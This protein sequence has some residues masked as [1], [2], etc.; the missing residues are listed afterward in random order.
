MFGLLRNCLIISLWLLSAPL[1]AQGEKLYFRPIGEGRGWGQNTIND[2]LQDQQGY[3]WLATWSGLARF[4]GYN[5]QVFNNNQGQSGGLQ[6][7]KITSVFEDSQGR[8]WIGTTYSGFYLYQAETESF[9][10]YL[11]QEDANSLA[12]N[13]IWEIKEDRFGKLWIGT[14][15]GLDEFDPQTETF[16]HYNTG[17]AR[18]N[19][20]H[21]FVYSIHESADGILWVGCETGFNRL[22]RDSAGRPLTFHLYEL[23][24]RGTPI[25]YDDE[26]RH[27]F[28]K[29]IQSSQYF[30]HTLWLG[31]SIGLKKFSYDPADPINFSCHTYYNQP[32]GLNHQFVASLLELPSEEELWIATY[33]GLNILDLKNDKFRYA[34]A[35]KN[36]SGSIPNNTLKSLYLDKF[37]VAW[38]GTDKGLS[39]L[40]LN[41]RPFR[42]LDLDVASYPN[43]NLITT[44][45]ASSDGQG[46]WVGSNGGGL[47]YISPSAEGRDWQFQHFPIQSK[48]VQDLANFV[49]DI[50]ISPEGELWVATQGAGILKMKESVDASGQ[51][52]LNI[53]QQYTKANQL[54]DDYFMSLAP[55]VERGVWFGYWDKGVDWYDPLAERF[56]HFGQLE[57]GPKLTEFPVIELINSQNNG[58]EY[59]WVATRGNGLFQFRFNAERKNLDLLHHFKFEANQSGGLSNDYL[60]C[61]YLQNADTLWIGTENGINVLDIKSGQIQHFS[62]QDGL[63]K[64]WIQSI[65][66]DANGNIWAGTQSGL[67]EIKLS[68][69]GAQITSYDVFDGLR[70]EFFSAQ[71]AGYSAAGELIF[72]TVSGLG[73]FHPNDIRFNKLPPKIA[74]NELRVFNRKVPIGPMPD[75]ETILSK[76]ISKTD[77][78]SLTHQQNV[79][80]IGFVGLHTGES[81]NISYAYKLEGFNQDWVYTETN[82][83][84][85]HYTNLPY[86]RFNFLVKAA[87]SDGV[88]SDPVQLK[89]NILPPFWR[90]NWAY[91]LYALLFIGLLYGVRK[92]TQLR[93]EYRL[94]LQLEKVEREKLEEVTRMKQQF[95][96]NISHELRTPL[97]LII[98]PLEQLIKD[99]N[100]DRSLYRSFQRMNLN[101]NRLLTMINQLLDIQKTESGLMRLRVGK[102]NL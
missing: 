72:G 95:F 13:N 88:W 26:L 55:G 68:P 38:V 2:I 60:N 40:N 42:H 28:I 96:T 1:F 34:K 4:D 48:E 36:Q 6:S 8:I 11:H 82:N 53:L 21:P 3:I 77:E 45:E 16:T 57:N 15:N 102:G 73:I 19:L 23:S 35:N 69:E 100:Y 5:H 25:S 37:G 44:I 39:I 10:Q 29:A 74:L 51:K 91:L 92:L 59:L 52:Q 98:S 62:E 54:S 65:I 80:S 94:N 78:I 86:K 81:Q 18:G 87:N 31:T 79:F 46:Y 17:K 93:A 33:N 32:G 30:E 64:K 27:N 66:S 85:A 24:P 58:Q 90:T 9:K 83:R 47:N 22:Q 14:E 71:S 41:A 70:N 97:T 12:N 67:A 89:I 99:R 76:S 7:N 20:S 101:A 56:Y 43:N 84:Q 75:G 63:P 50:T 49:K 61:L